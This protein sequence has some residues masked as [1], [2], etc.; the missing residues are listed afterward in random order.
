MFI[1]VLEQDDKPLQSC[2]DEFM[3]QQQLANTL[4]ASQEGLIWVTAS[5]EIIIH[6]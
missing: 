5:S 4:A 1:D 6:I 3:Q 2:T